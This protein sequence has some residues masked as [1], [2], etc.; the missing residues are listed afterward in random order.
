MGAAAP[1]QG[2]GGLRRGRG[3]GEGRRQGHASCRAGCGGGRGGLLWDRHRLRCG[4]HVQEGGPD[5]GFELLILGRGGP[6]HCGAHLD[7]VVRP[8]R[9]RRCLLSRGRCGA[10]RRLGRLGRPA[11]LRRLRSR[12]AGAGAGRH[13]L[14][15]RGRRAR[16]TRTPP[17]H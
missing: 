4:R 10:R 11:L 1:P 8:S 14:F 15:A 5:G 9:H 6:P 16:R 12:R 13:L 7:V 17:H 2:R 3:R